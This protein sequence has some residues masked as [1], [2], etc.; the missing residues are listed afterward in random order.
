M[1]I[2]RTTC[3]CVLANRRAEQPGDAVAHQELSDTLEELRERANRACEDTNCLVKDYHATI[4]RIQ[5]TISDR[6]RI[7]RK[8]DD[9]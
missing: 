7:V 5:R 1:P 3:T 4:E 8:M 9:V 2:P 6:Q